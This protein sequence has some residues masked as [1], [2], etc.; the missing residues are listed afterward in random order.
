MLLRT[1]LRLFIVGGICCLIL[2]GYFYI[3]ESA[4]LSWPST[5]GIVTESFVKLLH[6]SR[7]RN[8]IRPTVV[9][10]YV[11]NER[12]YVSSNRGYGIVAGPQYWAGEIVAKYPVGG[13]VTV[14]YD[15]NNP[16]DAVLEVGRGW[17]WP[18]TAAAGLLLIIPAIF[19]HYFLC[20]K[21]DKKVINKKRKRR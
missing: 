10:A 18:L 11:V 17:A 12:Q 4:T 13:V 14:Y 16:S 19:A 6:S 7:G 15:P 9:Y 1:Q 3:Q 2:S 5:Q 8:S 21:N 20:K